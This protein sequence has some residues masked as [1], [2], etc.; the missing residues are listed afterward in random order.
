LPDEVVER[1]RAK[2]LEAFR[3]LTGLDLEL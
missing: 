3:R 2:Y 1:T